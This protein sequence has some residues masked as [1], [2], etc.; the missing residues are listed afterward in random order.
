[1]PYILIPGSA[2]EIL[3]TQH[4]KDTVI[5]K[6]SRK[7]AIDT[8]NLEIVINAKENGCRFEGQKH[9]YT[10][11][12]VANSYQSEIA[13]TLFRLKFLIR[14]HALAL[15]VICLYGGTIFNLAKVSTILCMCTAALVDIK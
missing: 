1:M 5:L 4:I 3:W 9:G 11:T 14:Q 12:Y 10:H 2:Q 7:L 8:S 6:I 15:D 13:G